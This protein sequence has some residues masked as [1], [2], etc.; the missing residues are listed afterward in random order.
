MTTNPNNAVGTNAAY[1]GRIS[2]KAFNDNLSAYTSGVLS[3]WACSPSS[4]LTVSLGGDGT[5]RDVAI[6]EDPAGN[7]TTINNISGSPVNVT[8]DAAPASNSR[9]DL[10]V[11]YVTNPPEGTE[12]IADNPEACGIIA[13]KGTPAASPV[14]PNDTTIRSAITSDGSSGT[15]AYY[16]I[17][18]QITIASGT[19]DIV[20]ENIAAGASAIDNGVSNLADYF[21][22]NIINSYNRQNMT[23]VSGTMGDTVFKV[24][25]NAS[26]TLA[27]IYGIIRHKPTSTTTQ[28]INLNIDTGLRPETNMTVSPIGYMYP[29]YGTNNVL[30]E[31][32][33]IIIKTNGYIQIQYTPETVPSNFY[34][35]AAFPCLLFLKDWGDA[36]TSN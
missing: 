17:L 33:T 30:P 26:G 12:T 25:R 14:I 20:A 15:T 21:N 19:T 24:A 6:A 11:A 4:G 1:G 5:T 28:T 3:G 9:I 10:I 16:V 22:L 34:Y 23:P 2:V 7:K 35:G 32:L 18:A 31:E 13:V 29:I 8:L 27:K 36:P